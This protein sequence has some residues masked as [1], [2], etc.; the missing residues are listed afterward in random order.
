MWCNI[1]FIATR[2]VHSNQCLF[3]NDSPCRSVCLSSTLFPPSIS[4]I[5]SI[6]DHCHYN[7]PNIILVFLLFLFSLFFSRSTSFTVL[8]SYI[9][10]TWPAHYNLLTF[11]VVTTFGFP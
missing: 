2:S 5:T 6:S 4:W 3:Q 7:L 11:I 1:I 9:L 10:S 8:S